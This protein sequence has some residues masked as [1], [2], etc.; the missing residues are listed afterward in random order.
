MKTLHKDIKQILLEAQHRWL[1][2]AEICEIL[3]NYEKFHISPEAPNKPVLRY[4]RKDGHNWRKKKD[5]KT[6]KEAHEKLK[7]NKTNISGVRNND[8]AVSNSENES[9]LSSSFR[10]TSPT[11]TLSSAY[12]DAESGNQNVPALNYASLLRGDRDGDFGG[13]SL[14]SGAQETGDLALWQEVLGNPTTGEIAYKPETGFSLPVQ[15]NRQAL[16][17]LYEEKSL[18]S[19]HGNDAGTFYSYPEQ[20]GQS[21]ENNLQMLLSDGDAGNVMNPNMENVTAAI[22]NENYS[23]LLK[24]PLIGGLQTEKA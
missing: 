2:P 8:R 15:A 1:R 7:G 19:D 21:G 4:F 22:G 23:F 6:V 17:S 12:E 24:K 3:R 16:N 14:V 13:D 11:S 9:S 5:G 10:G 20:K 18:S